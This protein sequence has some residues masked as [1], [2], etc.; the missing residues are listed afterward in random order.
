MDAPPPPSPQPLHSSPTTASTVGA[1]QN[2][3][4]PVAAAGDLT[5]NDSNRMV[6][7]ET[8]P[9]GKSIAAVVAQRNPNVTKYREKGLKLPKEMECLLADV[10]TG[11]FA[12]APS[13][14]VMPMKRSRRQG[15]RSTTAANILHLLDRLVRVIESTATS[16]V[17]R[18]AGCS[19][20]EAMDVVRSLPGV[21]SCD[22]LFMM[23]MRSFRDAGNRDLFVNGLKS[24]GERV[25]WLQKELKDWH[26]S[27]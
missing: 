24:D 7:T 23:A 12:W 15:R 26:E 1:T 8:P 19:N 20:K 3:D 14:G 27:Q 25:A 9:L 11:A 4:P 5:S 16:S 21:Q 6:E 10:A 2:H 18:Q 22:P 13:S 17:P